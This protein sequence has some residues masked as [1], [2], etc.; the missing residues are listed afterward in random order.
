MLSGDVNPLA[1]MLVSFTLSAKQ[2]NTEV[3]HLARGECHA[4]RHEGS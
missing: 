3:V 2:A 4:T 1:P